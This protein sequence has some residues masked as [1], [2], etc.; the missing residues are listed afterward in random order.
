MNIRYLKPTS[1]TKA[2]EL[3]ARVN[4]IKG[5]KV[6]IECDVF[7][8]GIKTAQSEV[9]AIRVFSSLDSENTFIKTSS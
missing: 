2:I 3:R 4:E 1:N 5:K 7:S 8:E 9:I 6:V